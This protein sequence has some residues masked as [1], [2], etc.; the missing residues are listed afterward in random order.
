MSA[1]WNEHCS[2]Q[3]SRRVLRPAH[4]RPVLLQ[5]RRERRVSCRRDGVAVAFKI[6]SHNTL[7]LGAYQGAP[8]ESVGFFAESLPWRAADRPARLLRFGSLTASVRY[9]FVAS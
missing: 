9:L 1:L 3:H 5:V 2:Y 4:P 8:P 6:E 7:G